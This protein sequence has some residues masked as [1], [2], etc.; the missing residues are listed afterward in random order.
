MKNRLDYFFLNF[1][2]FWQKLTLGFCMAN[3]L[4]SKNPPAWWIFCDLGFFVSFPLLIEKNGVHNQK[5][6]GEAKQKRAKGLYKTAYFFF[7]GIVDKNSCDYHLQSIENHT[8]SEIFLLR[9]LFFFHKKAP[10]T[11]LLY[12]TTMT[13]AKKDGIHQRS[14]LL[15]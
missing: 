3:L 7:Q 13:K 6:S 2:V 8:F 4:I 11:S 9:F 15:S 14:H 1:S 12:Y 5:K 10:F